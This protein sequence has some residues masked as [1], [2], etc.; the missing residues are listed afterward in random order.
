MPRK[1]KLPIALIGGAFKD[2][3]Y[4]W[5]TS[6]DNHHA[7]VVG[8]D[9]DLTR[10]IRHKAHMVLNEIASLG[11]PVILCGHSLGALVAYEVA[12]IAP[13]NLVRG[14]GLINPAMIGGTY[15]GTDWTAAVELARNPFGLMRQLLQLMPERP[16][17]FFSLMTAATGGIEVDES[18]TNLLVVSGNSD[19]VTPPAHVR[20]VAER[21]GG[22]LMEVD[23]GHN[24]PI[25][26]TEGHILR[27]IAS[28]L[29]GNA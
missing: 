10:G 21:V 19:V 3:D 28:H 12:R 15:H 24:L 27:D 13:D 1:Q 2:P 14:T 16:E 23:G 20:E 18:I 6:R 25:D 7:R 9:Y 22:T 17:S 5:E 29:R 11:S 4:L 26:D 8:R